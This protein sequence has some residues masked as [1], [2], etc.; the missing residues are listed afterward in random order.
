[1]RCCCARYVEPTKK[2]ACSIYRAI[3]RSSCHYGPS[4]AKFYIRCSFTQSHKRAQN[5]KIKATFF[6]S[7]RDDLGVWVIILNLRHE[8]KQFIPKNF[9][10][11]LLLHRFFFLFALFEINSSS[12]QSTHLFTTTRNFFEFV[13]VDKMEILDCS[14]WWQGRMGWENTELRQKSTKLRELFAVITEEQKSV[15]VFT[16]A[17]RRLLADSLSW[18]FF[19]LF[20]YFLSWPSFTLL[21]CALRFQCLSI[22]NIHGFDVRN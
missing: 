6:S 5:N 1:M 3:S 4:G 2:K 18:F 14:G 17:R 11:F 13:V 19:S 8:S 15:V 9:A 12:I 20:S 7:S 22:K 21:D 16:Y 10:F